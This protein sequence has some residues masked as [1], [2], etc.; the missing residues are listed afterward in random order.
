MLLADG[1]L[2]MTLVVGSFGCRHQVVG[3]SLCV[4]CGLC[5][6]TCAP[7]C[8]VGSIATRPTGV[9]V[10]SARR[11]WSGGS[12]GNGRSKRLEPESR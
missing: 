2:R 9:M 10:E 7:R 11:S 3:S 6:E 12:F 1:Y 5:A 4:D 8:G